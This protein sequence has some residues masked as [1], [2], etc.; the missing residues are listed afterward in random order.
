[1]SVNEKAIV[2]YGA[3]QWTGDIHALLRANGMYM[4]MPPALRCDVVAILATMWDMGRKQGML[5]D[6]PY[7]VSV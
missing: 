2:H 3:T 6:V 1:M 4:Q 5:I 7:D